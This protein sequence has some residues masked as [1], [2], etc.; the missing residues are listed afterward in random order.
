MVGWWVLDILLVVRH[1][2]EAKGRSISL[3]ADCVH[4]ALSDI[5]LIIV[6]ATHTIQSSLETDTLCR[7]L[8]SLKEA[9]NY[10]LSF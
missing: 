9:I 2:G 1:S 5:A 3:T 7:S 4:L 6:R 10:E 8:F